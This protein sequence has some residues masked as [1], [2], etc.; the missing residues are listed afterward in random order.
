M[1]R[2]DILDCSRS[3]LLSWIDLRAQ[4]PCPKIM[5]GAAIVRRGPSGAETLILKNKPGRDNDNLHG[6]PGGEMKDAD[7]TVRDAIIRTVAES[8]SLQVIDV[9]NCLPPILDIQEETVED[10]TANGKETVENAVA[11]SSS[12][13]AQ[14]VVIRRPVVHFN[15][16]VNARGDGAGFQ[17][18]VEEH[19]MGIWIDAE[20]SAD[21]EMKD[22]MR[23]VVKTAV[24]L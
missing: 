21:I 24:R 16:V 8:V 4:I 19:E 3:D 13:A 5:V 10:S 11:G 15:F 7:S 22:A 6:I 20:K 23:D 9:W 1:L 12:Q 17:V 18:N 2:M 14:R